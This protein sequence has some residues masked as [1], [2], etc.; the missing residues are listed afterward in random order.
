MLYGYS[1]DLFSIYLSSVL[2][3]WGLVFALAGLEIYK[4]P[5][6]SENRMKLDNTVLQNRH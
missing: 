2:R 5:Y 1:K 4:T 3:V 6:R